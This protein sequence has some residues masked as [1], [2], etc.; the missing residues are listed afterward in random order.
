MHDVMQ[1]PYHFAMR[2]S[3]NYV[4]VFQWLGLWVFAAMARMGGKKRL[5]SAGNAGLVRCEDGGN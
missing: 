4:L 5:G 2:G 1:A 3:W